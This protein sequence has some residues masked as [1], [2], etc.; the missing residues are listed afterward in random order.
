MKTPRKTD[1]AI[2]RRSVLGL[3]ICAVVASTTAAVLPSDLMGSGGEKTSILKSKDKEFSEKLEK[4]FPGLASNAQFRLLAPLSAIV[5]HEKGPAV[6]AFSVSWTA[7]VGGETYETALFSYVRPRKKMTKRTQDGKTKR[8]KTVVSGQGNVL[9]EGESTLVTP[10][11]SMR[12]SAYKKNPDAWLSYVHKREPAG[13][14][15]NSLQENPVIDI[16]LD[17]VIY[18]N[19]KAVGPD[20]H[21]L[22]DRFSA[23]R[24]AERAQAK[25]VLNSLQRGDG[26][27][28]IASLLLQRATASRNVDQSVKGMF[29]RSRRHYAQVLLKSFQLLD[30]NRF[31][32]LVTAAASIH[33]T[34]IGA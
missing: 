29:W 16:G 13:F 7:K 2:S 6:R 26:R 31:T 15:V 3:G 25:E 33:H 5:T 28:E 10:F 21:Q 17:C 19:R 20:N 12:P 11:F 22:A 1:H 4:L 9:H 14:L 27:D 30:Q 23:R 24:N 34:R 18:G 8:G 32:R